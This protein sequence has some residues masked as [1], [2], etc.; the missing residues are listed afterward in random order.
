MCFL[1]NELD[2]FTLKKAMLVT[3]EDFGCILH[4]LK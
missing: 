3:S 1:N 4:E 2:N